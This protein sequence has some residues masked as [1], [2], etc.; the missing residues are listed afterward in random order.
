MTKIEERLASAK[1]HERVVGRLVGVS[2]REFPH[3]LIT[4]SPHHRFFFLLTSHL[5]PLLLLTHLTPLL[6]LLIFSSLL[7]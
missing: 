3:Y 6:N 4:S 1:P 7:V 5:S 2:N